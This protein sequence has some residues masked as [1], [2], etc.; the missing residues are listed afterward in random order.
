MVRVSPNTFMNTGDILTIGWAV[1]SFLSMV[2]IARHIRQVTKPRK[3]LLWAVVA[4][5]ERVSP[6]AYPQLQLSA[7]VQ[8]SDGPRTRLSSVTLRIGNAG[9][10]VIE[11][12][13]PTIQRNAGA[14]LLS[15]VPRFGRGQ[16]PT[17]VQGKIEGDSGRIAF[18]HISPGFDCE[19]D[20]LLSDYQ[21]G[22]LAIVEP[23]SEVNLRRCDPKRWA[24]TA[25]CS[26]N[27]GLRFYGLKYDLLN[28][29]R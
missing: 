15:I 11:Q 1:A 14:S 24:F 28:G 18:S 13:E 21:A 10:E 6:E 3:V 25:L 26:Q 23:S 4:E 19:I 27:F 29:K 16:D 22:S 9:T 12:T 2:A 8:A 17:C 20:L 7:S 5:N